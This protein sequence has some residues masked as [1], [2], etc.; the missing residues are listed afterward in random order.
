MYEKKHMPLHKAYCVQNECVECRDASRCG[1]KTIFSYSGHSFML[2]NYCVENECVDCTDA[3]HCDPSMQHHYPDGSKQQYAASMENFPEYKC[4]A[5]A[6]VP[7]YCYQGNECSSGYTCNYYHQCLPTLTK[8]ME[9]KQVSVAVASSSS[10]SVQPSQLPSGSVT[11]SSVPSVQPSTSPSEETCKV[12][13]CCEDGDCTSSSTTSGDFIG[14]TGPV[15]IRNRMGP[16]ITNP[17]GTVQ[18]QE[19]TPHCFENECV[20][21]TEASH[22]DPSVR[23]NDWPMVPH[24]FEN[25]CVECTD[26]SHCVFEWMID[27]S[28]SPEYECAGNACGVVQCPQGDECSSG[29]TCDKVY[30]CYPPY[31]ESTQKEASI[32]M[33]ETAVP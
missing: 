7:V 14:M 26:A 22:C 3:S 8:G 19:R 28:F 12:T 13:Q 1:F 21:C 15:V 33:S 16:V 2:P 5:N 24:C 25:E 32:V 4:S 6:C 10:P 31:P 17:D 27:S 9:Y 11:P 29:Y 30:G 20:E 23:F 18:V